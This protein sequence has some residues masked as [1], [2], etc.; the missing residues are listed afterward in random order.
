MKYHKVVQQSEN[1]LSL[2]KQNLL[3]WPKQFFILLK[4]FSKFHIALP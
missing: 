2:V 1:E 3:D 4:I